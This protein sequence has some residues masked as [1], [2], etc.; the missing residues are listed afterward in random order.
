MNC[1][2]NFRS[3]SALTVQI[4]W[5]VQSTLFGLSHQ[6]MFQWRNF[7]LRFFGAKIGNGAIIRPTFKITYPR[8]LTTPPFQGGD[9]FFLNTLLEKDNELKDF[10]LPA[11]EIALAL[12]RYISSQNST[13]VCSMFSPEHIKSNVKAMEKI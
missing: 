10:G 7:L 12:S 6:F 1:P 4:W 13:P 2:D 11:Q 9:L 8:E 3:R 5:F